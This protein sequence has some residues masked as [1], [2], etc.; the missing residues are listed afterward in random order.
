MKEIRKRHTH[1]KCDISIFEKFDRLI[2]ILTIHAPMPNRIVVKDVEVYRFS[3]VLLHLREN[4]C[5]L[6]LILI[7]FKTTRLHFSILKDFSFL[8]EYRNS[9]SFYLFKFT[10]FKKIENVFIFETGFQKLKYHNKK[11]AKR[12]E[13]VKQSFVQIDLS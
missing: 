10:F 6:I 12:L 5:S 8:I 2:R 7:F 4:T 3:R 9:I 13:K 11:S 1:P